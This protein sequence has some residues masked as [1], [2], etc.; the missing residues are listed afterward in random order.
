[1]VFILEDNTDVVE[2]FRPQVTRDLIFNYF[3]NTK[4]DEIIAPIINPINYHDNLMENQNSKDKQ[5]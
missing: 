1:M 5:S 3:I 2:C 4:F